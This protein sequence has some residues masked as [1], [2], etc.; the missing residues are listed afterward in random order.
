MAME[1]LTRAL[2]VEVAPIRVNLVV[3]GMVKTPLWGGIAQAERDAMFQHARSSL[4]VRHVAEPH[5][6][7]EAYVYCMRQSY[8]TG[9]SIV[10]DGGGLLV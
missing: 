5:E 1:G 10:V 8:G 4:P 2:A 9:Q 3:P 6:I 7:A